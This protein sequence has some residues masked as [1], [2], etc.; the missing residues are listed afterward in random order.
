MSIQNDRRELFSTKNEM[1]LR[2]F[3]KKV[4]Q[5]LSKVL[6]AQNTENGQSMENKNKMIFTETIRRRE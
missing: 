1:F 4:L 5:S 2:K 6:P 3:D